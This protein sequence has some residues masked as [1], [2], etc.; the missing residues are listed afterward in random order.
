VLDSDNNEAN[1]FFAISNGGDTSNW[2]F[3]VEE[4]GRIE[5]Q[6]I[7]TLPAIQGVSKATTSTATG[8][9][10]SATTSLT[11]R[12]VEGLGSKYGVYGTA[13]G[14]S[15]TQIGIY[16][17][18]TGTGSN[19]GG[20]FSATGSSI[21]TTYG[22]YSTATGTAGTKIGLYGSAT[23]AGA[24]TG[25][26]FNATSSSTSTTYGV[27]AQVQP[28]GT[29]AAKD[30]ACALYA[31]PLSSNDVND[32]AFGLYVNASNTSD[33][34]TN[35]S[36]LSADTPDPVPAYMTRY[37]V[38]VNGAGS[39]DWPTGEHVSGGYFR[40]VSGGAADFNYGVRTNATSHAGNSLDTVYG[41]YSKATSAE[42]NDGV[43]GVYADVSGTS[44]FYKTGVR[45]IATG[46]STSSN[47][48]VEA[49]ASGASVKN[50]GV[51]AT[52]SG[53]TT[54]N[55]GVYA[56]GSGTGAYAGYFAGAPVKVTDSVEIGAKSTRFGM[57]RVNLTSASTW[58]NLFVHPGQSSLSLQWSGS[59]TAPAT[60]RVMNT[61]GT[62]FDASIWTSAASVD[63]VSTTSG[64][65]TWG[66]PVSRQAIN[67]NESGWNATVGQEGGAGPGFVFMGTSFVQKIQG[68]VIYWW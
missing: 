45:A 29:S 4:S 51:Y 67:Q 42:S 11:G 55:I 54:E 18:A 17:V 49:N 46:V 63:A 33:P 8:L 28:N 10:G 52:A 41:L 2:V 31:R 34:V 24:N 62:F 47:R 65:T 32:T 50:Y 23:G 66:N 60:L 13:N 27:V 15:G 43:T 61:T 48:G 30:N 58:T 56:S 3:R 37:G 64:A 57:E 5:V 39:T 26:F 9:F 68:I 40:V 6:S 38:Y 7:S 14:T 44:A 35:F 16:G 20:L 53:A 19:T 12:G 36:R 21:S 59:L 1:A 25:G 22:V